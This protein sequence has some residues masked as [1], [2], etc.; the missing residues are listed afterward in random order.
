MKTHSNIIKKALIVTSLLIVS[1]VQAIY[2]QSLTIT[3]TIYDYNGLPIFGATVQ[4]DS[5]GGGTITNEEGQFTLEIASEQTKLTFSYI[6]M[7]P[8]TRV[9][10]D[11]RDFQI[12]LKSDNVKL[13]ELVVVGYT[14]QRKKDITGAV[15]VVDVGEMIKQGE[16]NPIKALQGRV[17]GVNITS[18]GSPSGAST[19]R[20]R[21]IGTLNNNDP[22]YVIDGVATKGGMHELNPADIENIQILRDAASASIYGCRAANGVIII[23][24]KKGKGGKAKVNFDASFSS[25]Q[26]GEVIDMLNTKE[27]GTVQWQ[28]MMNSATDP[29]SNQI[30][31]VYDYSYDNEGRPLLNSM[32]LPKYIDARDGSNTM[33]TGDTDWFDEITK[34][35]LTQ[36]YNLSVSNS[37]EK[38]NSFFSLGYYDNNGTVK[39]TNFKRFSS[40]INTSYKLFGDLITIGENIT[41]NNTK[42]LQMPDGVLNLAIQSLPVMP[43]HT[44]DGD[45]GYVTSGMNDRDNPARI[46]DAN[47]NNPYDYWRIFGNAYINIQPAKNLSIKSSFGIDNSNYFQR[48][49]TTSFTGRLGSDLTSSKLIQS[50]YQKFTW[51][52]TANYSFD[53]RKSHFSILLGSEIIKHNDINFSAEKRSYEVEDPDYM[54]PNAGVGEAFATGGSTGSSLNSY[55]GKINYTYGDKYLASATVRRDG[56]SRFGKN[57]RYATFPAFTAGWRINQES[58]MDFAKSYMSDLKLRLSYGLTGNQEIDNYAIRTLIV[59]NYI[60]DTGA[61]I[62]SGTAY[63]IAGENSGLLPSGYQLTQRSNDDLKWETT[64][65]FNIGL[66]FGFFKQNLYGSAEWYKKSTVDI[67][68]VPPYLGAIGEGGDHWVNGASMEN[69][70]LELALG[71]RAN[72]SSDFSY[73][74]AANI[75]GYRNKIT[76]LPES[77][78]NSYGGNGTTDNILGRT[79]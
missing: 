26:F 10:G 1:S 2:A 27:F 45:W 7:E 52:N 28:A 76:M 40:R 12:T 63:D 36:S 17:P 16:N 29:N 47:K 14:T 33:L 55:F 61:G 39:H 32:A 75:S 38:S 31:Y 18:N 57:N 22:L 53:I 66:D 41:F 65:Q 15:S 64:T 30:G 44:E 46:L 51:T 35:G 11:V 48:A 59:T 13:D 74:I 67:L 6:G 71:Y 49:L 69:V 62:N 73:D 77:V 42:E 34:I 50:H 25:S 21:G 70:G 58:F 79:N 9:V 24:T 54:W 68:I 23:T 20:I 3:G 37:N 5:N 72:T 8:Q 19:V 60:G 78:V 43:V 4:E 56:S